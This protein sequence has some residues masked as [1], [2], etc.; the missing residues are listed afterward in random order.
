MR[1]LQFHSFSSNCAVRL[2]ALCAHA[3]G[4]KPKKSSLQ[5]APQFL[6][7]VTININSMQNQHKPQWY[8]ARTERRI[9]TKIMN[10]SFCSHDNGQ[11]LHSAQ[12]KI[13]TKQIL[14]SAATMTGSTLYSLKCKSLVW[15]LIIDL[16][17]PHKPVPG[18]KENSN[19]ICHLS[20]DIKK[21][22]RFVHSQNLTS[23]SPEYFL[24]WVALFVYLEGGGGMPILLQLRNKKYSFLR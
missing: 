19:S 6:F 21:D 1:F 10:T 24:T 13:I 4:K 7:F 18:Y 15:T 8:V 9:I 22:P 16:H 17:Q 2:K 12:P 23:E 3:H 20:K 14:C 5:G 11:H